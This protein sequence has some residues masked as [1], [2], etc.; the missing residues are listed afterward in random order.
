MP[1]TALRRRRFFDPAEAINAPSD[2]SYE[3]RSSDPTDNIGAPREVAKYCKTLFEDQQ[4]QPVLQ[5]TELRRVVERNEKSSNSF[6]PIVQRANGQMALVAC[7][8]GW[9]SWT[10]S[11]GKWG[12]LAELRCC[13][14][15]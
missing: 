2:G 4:E 11:R 15:G 10:F 8:V 9:V 1:P 14:F 3:H 13:C 12:K 7:V 5:A 6:R